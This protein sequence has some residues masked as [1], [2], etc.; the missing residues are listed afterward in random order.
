MNLLSNDV[1][2]FDIVLFFLHYLWSAPIGTLAIAYYLWLQAGIS[3]LMGILAVLI[4]VPL[5]CKSRFG[6]VFVNMLMS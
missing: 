5:Q 1:S 4:V 3:G 6:I 2:R